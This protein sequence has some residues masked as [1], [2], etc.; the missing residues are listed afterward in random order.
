MAKLQNKNII[1][2]ICGS[3]SAY[4]TPNLV[5]LLVKDGFDV[6]CVV[7]ESAK[8]FVTES[9]LSNLSKKKVI[10]DLF[11]NEYSDDGA[12]HIKLSHNVGLCLIAPCSATTLS[13]IANGICDNA[14]TTLVCA[15]PSNIKVVIY[16]AMDFTMWE[17][18]IIQLNVKKLRDLG[19]DVRE[20][21]V[22]ELS[23]G[24]FGKGRLVEESKIVEYLS[25]NS[26]NH[27]KENKREINKVDY[28]DSIKINTELDFELLKS[29]MSK[30]RA[31]N[32]FFTLGPTIEKIDD[33]RYISNFSSGKMGLELAKEAQFRGMNV[34]IVN[35]PVNLDL[36]EF[37][38]IEVTSADEMYEKVMNE[39]VKN[40]II[41]MAAAVADYK[42]K[43][44]FQGKIKKQDNNEFNINLIK[45]KDILKSLGSNKSNKQVI[46]G[47]ALETNE[48][49]E[50]AQ[51][52]LL[53]KNADLIVLNTLNSENNVFN[54]D[55]NIISIIS[56]NN[57]VDY[58]KMP[59]RDCAKAI[60]DNI[61]KLILSN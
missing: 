36:S 51:R 15:L 35:G 6:Q 7:T 12:W 52:K 55:D 43:N 57:I 24:L 59:K 46:V 47:F 25:N 16:P 8:Q 31:K 11:D 13:K 19:Y 39:Y 10:S 22:G 2:G 21:E 60:L 56:K 58:N 20:P 32:C 17:N 50:N 1:L 38:A 48:G 29:E 5:R 4:K 27:I 45:N 28:K 61:D 37:N 30:V 9:T 14:L 40:D 33:V 42:V 44:P 54:N 23:S 26:N 41:I 49:R 53:E 18:P 34:T 3:I